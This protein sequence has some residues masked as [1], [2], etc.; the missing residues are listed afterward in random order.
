[1]KFIALILALLFIQY[2][3]SAQMLHRD[4][5][6]ESFRSWLS[7]LNLPKSAGIAFAVLAPTLFLYWSLYE[8]SGWV[9]GL[10]VLAI[11]VLVLLYS[12]GRGDYEAA[13]SGYRQHCRDGDFEAAFLVT[14][15]LFPCQPCDAD[16]EDAEH[17]HRWMKKRLLY[18]G[19]ERWFAVIFYFALLGAPGALAYRL[20]Q[21]IGTTPESDDAEDARNHLVHW[22]D[23][24]PSR[25]LVFAFSLTGDYM[26]SREQT[27]AAVQE[28]ESA[29]DEVIADAA[30]AAL[31]FK[32]TVFTD[33]G[34]AEAY[35]Q[36]S[37]WEMGQLHSLMSRS[38]VAWVAVISLFVVF[39]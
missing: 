29:A 20:A 17:L 36:V 19:F 21:I 14:R 4:E 22:L 30:H 13:M 12:F 6:F 25:L 15:E 27:M 34:D 2:W 10:P 3:G 18:M 39:A 8:V 5:W 32:S 7:G 16:A 9:F 26:G 23:W 35:A 1:V 38:A 24:L 28:L 31:G 33:N 11:N 37:E